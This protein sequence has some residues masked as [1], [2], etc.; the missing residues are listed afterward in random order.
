MVIELPFALSYK[1]QE[2]IDDLEDRL[3]EINGEI[4]RL[5]DEISDL[6]NERYEI[7]K[8]L[9]N[10]GATSVCDLS[11]ILP[12]PFFHK[13]YKLYYLIYEEPVPA[14]QLSWFGTNPKSLKQTGTILKD[15]DDNPVKFWPGIA[16]IA[17]IL[18][19]IDK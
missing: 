17:D 4:D 9:K 8:K 18:G 6:E 13:K 16:T 1:R 5:E 10:D 7:N 11:K 19:L 3:E 14:E 2:K 15:K 12:S